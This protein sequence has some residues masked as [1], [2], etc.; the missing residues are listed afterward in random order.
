MPQN[1]PREPRLLFLFPGC[2][3]LKPGFHLDKIDGICR[4][5]EC[6]KKNRKKKRK[7]ECVLQKGN[8]NKLKL[9][10][11]REPTFCF[12]FRMLWTNQTRNRMARECPATC[13]AARGD[14]ISWPHQAANHRW[15]CCMPFKTQASKREQSPN[16]ELPQSGFHRNLDVRCRAEQM[17]DIGEVEVSRTNAEWEQQNIKECE[18]NQHRSYEG[19]R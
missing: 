2:H 7:K 12:Y 13:R 9:N 6:E 5:Q 1:V 10:T 16:R 15:Q 4:N 19:N 17:S 3:K 8:E 14:Q 18:R 11:L